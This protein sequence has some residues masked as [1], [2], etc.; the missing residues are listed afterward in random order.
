MLYGESGSVNAPKLLR[1]PGMQLRCRQKAGGGGS[2]PSLATTFSITYSFYTCHREG[3]P[4]HADG[5]LGK[6]RVFNDVS[7]LVDRLC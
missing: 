1:M 6:I 5:T 3:S 2:I 4:R 7:K